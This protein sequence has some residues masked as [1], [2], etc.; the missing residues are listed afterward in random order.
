MA[1]VNKGVRLGR[2]GRPRTEESP[3]YDQ[4]RNR[5]RRRTPESPALLEPRSPIAARS[6]RAK[7]NSWDQ[8]GHPAQGRS[9][10]IDQVTDRFGDANPQ[11]APCASRSPHRRV[12][13]RGCAGPA[14]D[15]AAP[16]D[17]IAGL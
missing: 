8:L 9:M 16:D 17:E 1:L 12:V 14:A 3:A 10:P 6:I 2:L 13:K 5:F 15:R 11:P 7:S 4:V